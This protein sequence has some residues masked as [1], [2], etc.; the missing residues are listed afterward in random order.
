LELKEKGIKIAAFTESY[1]FFTK[2]RLKHLGLDGFIDCIYSPKDYD[3]A[4]FCFP[5]FLNIEQASKMALYN[6]SSFC[7]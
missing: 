1:V 3:T 4:S 7:F 5:I 6:Y 2:Y